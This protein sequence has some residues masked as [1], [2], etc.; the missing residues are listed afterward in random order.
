MARIARHSIDEV[1]NNADI[2]SVIQARV[3]LKRRGANYWAC[4]PFH[5]EKTPSFSVSAQRQFYKCFGCGASGNVF[6]FLIETEKLS[7]P[8]AVE[9]LANQFGVQLEYEGGRAP[10]TNRGLQSRCYDQLGWASEQFRKHLSVAPTA[11]EYLQSRGMADVAERWDIGFAPDEWRTIT[12]ASLEKFRDQ[13]A[14]LASGLAR[15]S[16]NGRVYDFFRGRVIFPIRD[17]QGRVIG[18]GA[19]VLD[20]D[21][22]EQKYLNSPEGPV[23]HK[24]RALYAIDRLSR[25]ERLKTDK[26]VLVMEGYTDVIA[27]HENG[28]D[29]AVAPCGTSI[30]VEQLRLLKRFSDG[31]TLVLDGDAAGRKAAERAS[32]LG[33][34]YGFD[35]RVVLLPQGADP[36]DMLFG[37]KTDEFAALINGAQDSFDFVLDTIAGRHDIQR[38]IEAERALREAVELVSRAQSQTLR[39]FLG[40]R[41][42]ARFQLKEDV[43]LGG[44]SAPNDRQRQSAPIR[45]QP[46]GANVAFERSLLAGLIRFP[47]ALNNADDVCAP[48]AFSNALCGELYRR[49][50]NHWDE[51]GGIDAAAMLDELAPETRNEWTTILDLV[52]M[53]TSQAT[54]DEQRLHAALREFGSR[55][56]PR[57][58]TSLEELRRSRK[59]RMKA[60]NSQNTG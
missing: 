38:P 28:F 57:K 9:R 16:E 27:A 12:D 39:E 20:P 24:S 54:D 14:L 58:A 4:C 7:F 51:Y 43:V 60:K 31:I 35:I 37:G 1:R 42:A 29:N 11:L 52:D 41:V 48:E 53:T 5:D 33:L 13:E 30:T 44:V 49:M 36:F 21:A 17:Q 45:P 6:S 23:Y 34:E 26:R 25:S 19:R 15:Q 8:E 3:P 32:G 10:T 59:N 22:K 46:T 50:L 56:K 47:K 18:F 40:R 55:S 2:V